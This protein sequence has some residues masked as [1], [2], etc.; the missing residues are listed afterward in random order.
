MTNT[1]PIKNRSDKSDPPQKISV[2]EMIIFS[3]PQ[4]TIAD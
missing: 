2:K 1:N 3:T 4:D